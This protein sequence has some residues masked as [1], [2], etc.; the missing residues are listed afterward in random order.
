[1]SES[2]TSRSDAGLGSA[3]RK[4]V[5]IVL[6]LCLI[7]AGWLAVKYFR[8][9][10]MLGYVDSAIGRVRV[11]SAAEERFAKAHPKIGYTCELA[12]LSGDNQVDNEQIQRLQRQP[13]ENGYSFALV[14][15]QAT[16]PGKPNSVYYVT[17]R[18]ISRGLGAF[19]SAPS[20]I[21]EYHESGS[22]ENCIARGVPYN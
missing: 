22:V 3:G 20:G 7:G 6:V 12:Q 21:L 1:M 4:Y 10:L 5:R 9:L 14:G 19:C 2:G 8:G 13:V 16:A 17:A 18:P 15:C 11:L